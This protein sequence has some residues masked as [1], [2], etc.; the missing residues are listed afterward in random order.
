M[1]RILLFLLISQSFSIAQAQESFELDY[2]EKFFNMV[3]SPQEYNDW[4][5]NDGFSKTG[6]ASDVTKK[7]YQYMKDDFDFIFFISNEDE[8]PATVPYYGKFAYVSNNIQ[9]IG[10]SIFDHTGSFGSAGKLQGV[11][12]IPYRSG[13]RYGPSLHEFMHNWGNNALQTGI[14]TQDGP[15]NNY[16][17]HWGF[18]GGSTPGQ[19]GGFAQSSLLTNVN[20]DPNRYSVLSFG[21]NAN[22]GN[23]VPYSKLE[24][25]LMGMI[26]ASEVSTFDLFRDITSVTGVGDRYEFTANTRETYNGAS[27][28]AKLGVRVP[29]Y[30][31]SQKD[32]KVLFVVV[33]GS[34]LSEDERNEIHNQITW[35]ANNSNDD[36]SSYNFFEA[37]EGHGT[38]NV[39]DLAASKKNALNLSLLSHNNAQSVTA[40]AP[41]EIKWQ[42]DIQGDLK[43]ELYQN[44]TYF[45]TLTT[46][47]PASSQSYFW[48]PAI[49]DVGNLFR[50]KITSTSNEDTYDF[51]NLSFG[52]LHRYFTIS[53]TVTE[54]NGNPM[55]NATVLLG[56]VVVKDQSQIQASASSYLSLQPK[57]Q[58]FRP[59][60]NYISK[61]DLRLLSGSEAHEFVVV[62]IA[63]SNGISLGSDTLFHSELSNG[64]YTSVQFIPAVKVSPGKKFLIKVK[65]SPESTFFWYYSS[66]STYSEG[67]NQDGG[68]N[69]Y[70]FITYS[71]NGYAI[72][73]DIAGNFSFRINEGFSGDLTVVNKNTLYQMVPASRTYNELSN[74]ATE[75]NFSLK[76]PLRIS[77]KVLTSSNT[78]INGALVTW[79]EPLQVDQ[80]LT[81]WVHGYYLSPYS[82][83][84]SFVPAADQISQMQFLV[85][86]GQ[87][88][89]EPIVVEIKKGE[90][91]IATQIIPPSAPNLS[92]YWATAPFIPAVSVE[93]GQEYT[94]FLSTAATNNNYLWFGSD[95]NEYLQGKSINIIDQNFDFCFISQYGNGGSTYADPSGYYEFRLP[96][97]WDGEINA[98]RTGFTFYP[99]YYSD[100][101]GNYENQDFKDGAVTSLHKS[102]ISEDIKV[103]P[104]PASKFFFIE[105]AASLDP[106]NSVEISEANGTHI[107]RVLLNSAINHSIDI[108]DLP[109]GIYLVKMSGKERVLFT[110]IIKL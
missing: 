104:N 16:S 2:Q 41:T 84:Q 31:N 48:T 38:I 58:S 25:Y 99:R 70:C 74:T 108:S 90:E 77:G 49:D 7:V 13:L 5:Q 32:F 60:G 33:S 37:T 100:I 102:V 94:V 23:S 105:D 30:L 35:F 43:I 110:K 42:T 50:I 34:P 71:G 103:F 88:T 29:D 62:E 54:D 93:P 66:A 89:P 97:G 61:L 59:T 39:S 46:G 27:L 18:T 91:L 11:M 80:Q 15:I 6:G 69:D 81:N 22:G 26:P 21:Y 9:G 87:P 57:T 3:I 40:G 36:V 28:E 1:K 96:E 73:T 10:Q 14:Y 92:R 24:L 44:G 76:S 86:N 75:Q 101:T 64:Y 17:G 85:Y 67:E 51:S 55:Q 12:H 106:I 63:D 95:A 107:R 82:S 52:I 68:T 98:S 79:G 56:D 47:I 78:P 19:L 8:L 4:I 65:A 20:G 45:K 109:A 72:Q 53:G 83:G